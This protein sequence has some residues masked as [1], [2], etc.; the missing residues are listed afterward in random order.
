MGNAVKPTEALIRFAR[1]LSCYDFRLEDIPLLRPQSKYH[2]LAKVQQY[3]QRPVPVHLRYLYPLGISTILCKKEDVDAAQRMLASTNTQET[4]LPLHGVVD[5]FH[6]FPNHRTVV[7]WHKL[8]GIDYGAVYEWGDECA[9]TVIV[10]VMDCE[11]EPDYSLQG[12]IARGSRLR[13][14]LKKRDI[15]LRTPVL[16]YI[17]LAMLEVNPFLTLPQMRI[18]L[19]K[20]AEF[21]DVDP[22][23]IEEVALRMKYLYKYYRLLSTSYVAGRIWIHIEGP[24]YYRKMGGPVTG[25]LEAPRPCIDVVYGWLAASRLGARIIVPL[26]EGNVYA[27][28]IL[29]APGA[30]E[31]LRQLA[32]HCAFDIHVR[33]RSGFTPFPFEYFD[34][35]RVKWGLEPHEEYTKLLR[36]IRLVAEQAA[37]ARL[38]SLRGRQ[39]RGKGRERDEEREPGS[40]ID[41]ED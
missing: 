5:F 22:S 16:A 33:L 7:G 6:V 20:A 21:R 34:P 19:K 41:V 38:N 24:D 39:G 17:I 8:P 13:L 36:K 14:L 9:E 32:R 37:L 30:A 18:S 3:F 25:L 2:Y 15:R 4:G 28:I 40:N 1:M 10:P 26:E 11:G 35:I 23:L 29:N 27:P 12:L 31:A